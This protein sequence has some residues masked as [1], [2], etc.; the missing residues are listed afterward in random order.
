MESSCADMALDASQSHLLGRHGMRKYGHDIRLL[1]RPANRIA[2]NNPAHPDITRSL[3]FHKQ[4]PSRRLD[5]LSL[6]SS[7]SS[8]QALTATPEI[9]IWLC[10]SSTP[11]R[12]PLDARSQWRNHN[13]NTEASAS[14]S[15]T[16]K[17]SPEHP[18]SR[19]APTTPCD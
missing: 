12:S 2:F 3:K 18:R 4:P 16:T 8:S 19:S 7:S 14:R 13:T 5:L 11:Y 15:R 1:Q 6:S 9:S 17:T 10:K